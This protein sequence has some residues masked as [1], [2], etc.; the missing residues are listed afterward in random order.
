VSK[1]AV[2]PLPVIASVR[3]SV[4]EA[5][6]DA[7]GLARCETGLALGG[8]GGARLTPALRAAVARLALDAAR[9]KALKTNK[10]SDRSGC[11]QSLSR[12]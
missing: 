6:R 12:S 10:A 8:G 1:G 3:D 7:V 2:L 4:R 9:A 11:P 5:V